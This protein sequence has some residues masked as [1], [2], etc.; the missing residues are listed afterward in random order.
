MA[1][2]VACLQCG[3]QVSPLCT[4]CPRCRAPRKASGGV[5]ITL[6]VG[7]VIPMLVAVA[8]ISHIANKDRAPGPTVAPLAPA[9]AAPARPIA[10]TAPLP[11]TVEPDPVAVSAGQLYKDYGTNEVG[12]DERYKGRVLL[13]TG[14]VGEIRK[15]LADEPYLTFLAAGGRERVR[16]R[17]RE[18][19]ATSL[20]R[21]SPNDV[22][23][24]RCVGE[25][26]LGRPKLKDCVIQ[27][28]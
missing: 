5:L 22:V 6:L 20:G 2:L 1:T 27:Q 17:F 14:I 26:W 10:P 13:V 18:G 28:P 4:V 21:L 19:G 11:A 7:I 25:N 9:T 24:M 12:A 23:A 3:N 16:A 15:D 8:L